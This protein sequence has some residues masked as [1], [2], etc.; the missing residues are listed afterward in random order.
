[1]SEVLEF[2][3]GNV[4]VRL[5]TNTDLNLSDGI[6][7]FCHDAVLLAHV[8]LAYVLIPHVCYIALVIGLLAYVLPHIWDVILANMFG[9]HTSAICDTCLSPDVRHLAL[10]ILEYVLAPHVIIR[11]DTTRLALLI[12]D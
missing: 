12:L 11:S 7:P 2:G 9:Y 5:K 10:V 4:M 6:N 3:A 1:M 8:L